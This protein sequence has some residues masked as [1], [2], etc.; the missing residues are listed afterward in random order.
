MI[1]LDYKVL[2]KLGDIYMKLEIIEEK[3]KGLEDKIH[4]DYDRVFKEYESLSLKDLRKEK[5]I[6]STRMSA[7]DLVAK[8]YGPDRSYARIVMNLTVV[9][10][11]ASFI[12]MLFPYAKISKA[13]SCIILL[14]YLIVAFIILCLSNSLGSSK[15]YDHLDSKYLDDKLRLAVLNQIIEERQYP[16]LKRHSNEQL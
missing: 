1:L 12:N 4:N 13:I 10:I 11:F 16:E 5:V 9:N 14:S 7:D 8:K 2:Y 3:A 15:Q 6:I